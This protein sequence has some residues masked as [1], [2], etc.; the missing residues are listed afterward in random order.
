AGVRG[1]GPRG[2]M[3]ALMADLD[4][5]VQVSTEPEPFGLVH[6][7]ALASGTPVVAGDAGGP[8]EILE[9]LDP[10]AGRLVAA[11]DPVALAAAVAALLPARPSSTAARRARPVLRAGGTPDWDALFGEVLGGSRRRRT[12]PRRRGS[13]SRAPFG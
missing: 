9:G 10:S 13:A 11:G 1:L 4:V 6:A 3:A 7:E 5:F 8:V 2:D 12:S